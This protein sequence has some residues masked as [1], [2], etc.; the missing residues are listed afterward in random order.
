MR[1]APRVRTELG[2]VGGGESS[3]APVSTD[4]DFSNAGDSPLRVMRSI[5]S[6][7]THTCSKKENRTQLWFGLVGTYARAGRPVKHCW[8]PFYQTK[9]KHWLFSA[10]CN[11]FKTGKQSVHACVCVFACTRI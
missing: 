7:T 3:K 2:G 1:G 8:K 10:L 9:G 11:F 4:H 6:L 5:Q